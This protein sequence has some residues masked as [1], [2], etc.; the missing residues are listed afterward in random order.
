MLPMMH[1]CGSP[2]TSCAEYICPALQFFRASARLSIGG[3]S[4]EPI[5]VTTGWPVPLIGAASATVNDWFVLV[6]DHAVRQA[7]PIKRPEINAAAAVLIIFN[8]FSFGNPA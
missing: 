5:T 2:T 7:P 3:N 6:A 1:A 8:V 4:G